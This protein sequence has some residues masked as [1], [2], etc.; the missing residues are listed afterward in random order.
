[1]ELKNMIRDAGANIFNWSCRDLALKRDLD[2]LKVD[3]IYTDVSELIMNDPDFKKFVVR[4][5]ELDKPV[6]MK[7]YMVIFKVLTTLTKDENM[8]ATIDRIYDINVEEPQNQ[9]DNINRIHPPQLRRNFK[10]TADHKK[11]LHPVRRKKQEPQEIVIGDSSSDSDIDEIEIVGMKAGTHTVINLA[12]DDDE[13]E[14]DKGAE[15]KQKEAVEK[16]EQPPSTGKQPQKKQPIYKRPDPTSPPP[17]RPR[18]YDFGDFVIS[19]PGSD[20]TITEEQ[21]ISDANGSLDVN[22]TNENDVEMA[23]IS[24]PIQIDQPI[25]RYVKAYQS[26]QRENFKGFDT[27]DVKIKSLYFDSNKESHEKISDN[28]NKDNL[29]EEEFKKDDLKEP[30]SVVWREEDCTFVCFHDR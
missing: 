5:K 9:S 19:S 21:I 12:S 7:S 8:R 26:F 3:T 13:T 10:V 28:N 27:G 22:I 6:V 14:G 23:G 29:L 16:M 24:E 18:F 11:V 15:K 30:I 1:M 17:K 20:S 4:R 2:L 25:S